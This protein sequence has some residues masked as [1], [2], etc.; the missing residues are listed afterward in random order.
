MT[1]SPRFLAN[2]AKKDLPDQWSNTKKLAN[3]IKI[4][5]SPLVQRE[6]NTIKKRIVL[7][8]IRQ[9]LYKDFFKNYE[10]FK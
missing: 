7:F 2:N 10:F 5:I 3:S 8:D 6:A 4:A 9:V 1:V